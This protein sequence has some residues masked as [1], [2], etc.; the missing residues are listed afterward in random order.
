MRTTP[1]PG[2]ALRL[3]VAGLVLSAS[4]GSAS[5]DPTLTGT[6]LIRLERDDSALLARVVASDGVQ[7]AEHRAG[8]WPLYTLSLT[9]PAAA[10]RVA[11]DLQGVPG[12]RWA[13]ADRVVPTELHA[14][15]ID[16]VYADQLWHLENTAQVPGGL[17]GADIDVV[18]AW[19]ITHGEGQLICVIDGGVETSH[20]DLAIRFP[21]W[22]AIDQ[23]TDPNPGEGQDNAG[24]GTLV[25]GLAAAVGNNA[26]GVA[27]VAYAAE[28]F[29]IR[30]IGGSITQSAMYDA[31]VRGVDAGCTVLNNSWGYIPQDPCSAIGELP[32]MNEALEYARTVG[33]DGLGAVVVFSAGNQ[34]CEQNNYPMLNNNPGVIAVASVTDQAR[35]WGYSVWGAHVDMAAPS[36]PTGGG[37]RPGLWSTDMWGDAGFNGQGENNE[38]SDRMGGTSGAAPVVAGTVALMLAANPRAPE[39]AVREILCATADKIDPGFGDYDATGWSPYYGCG[40]VDAGAAV[41]AIA[42]AAPPAP[43]M[44]SPGPGGPLV[45]GEGALR[46][47]PVE[48]PDGDALTYAVQIRAAL[49]DDDSAEDDDEV[50][51]RAGLAEPSYR[52]H[53]LDWEP[54][55]YA[56]RV[57]ARDLWGQGEW[58]AWQDVELV[59]PDPPAPVE[60]EETGCGG[61]GAALLLLLMPLGVRRRA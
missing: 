21:G 40:R 51:L 29:P 55:T 24:H 19:Q 59:R 3:G 17:V 14:L 37:P 42:N 49:G 39:S 20:P 52:L 36:G 47:S 10:E 60:P 16:D 13:W 31:F 22:D 56:V 15:P 12:V 33:R 1:I 7:G 32:A 44:L 18:P 45:L 6:V 27:G 46:W 48:D 2:I 54:G 35:K 50:A 53:P 38:Y 43:D 25:A 30:A 26:L 34:G 57:G 61:G 23:D 9:D 28:V 8:A 58:S 4:M 11:R 5:A 41:A